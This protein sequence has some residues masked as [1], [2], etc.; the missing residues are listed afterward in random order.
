MRIFKSWWQFV[1]HTLH[2]MVRQKISKVT[3]R[4]IE[5]LKGLLICLIG[6]L[7][8]SDIATAQEVPVPA[9]LKSFPSA[10]C[11]WA[12]GVERLSTT[13]DGIHNYIIRVSLQQQDSVGNNKG[14]LKL[15]HALIYCTYSDTGIPK[16]IKFKQKGFLWIAKFEV[17][18]NQPVPLK[19]IAAYNHQQTEMPLTLNKG[20]Y[21]GEPDQVSEEKL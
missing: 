11:Y 13:K 20:T 4:R 8:I 21:P 19:I 5:Q 14:R 9:S 7:P 2:F 12:Y 15:K 16:K 10:K 17:S 18:T 3:Q 1:R 6:F